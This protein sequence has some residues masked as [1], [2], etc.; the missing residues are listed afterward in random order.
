MLV[1]G[2][3]FIVTTSTNIIITIT[4]TMVDVA[5]FYND[6]SNSTFKKSKKLG[7]SKFYSSNSSTLTANSVFSSTSQSTLSQ[8]SHLQSMYQSTKDF[9]NNNSVNL[10]GSNN[11]STNNGRIYDTTMAKPISS[12]K[13][14]AEWLCSRPKARIHI[15]CQRLGSYYDPV[16][17]L[18]IH[19]IMYINNKNI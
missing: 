1:Q 17:Q 5:M 9:N 3:V 11:N 16:I 7:F 4:I 15:Y 2:N 12:F 13:A 19:N 10:N 18:C 14:R 6:I 8:N